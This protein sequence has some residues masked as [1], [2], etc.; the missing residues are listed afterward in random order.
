MSKIFTVHMD[1]I[2][3]DTHTVRA[4]SSEEAIKIALE[5]SY[6]SAIEEFEYYNSMVQE[7]KDVEGMLVDNE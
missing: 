3:T 1:L 5:L 6:D 7:E 2:H 4:E